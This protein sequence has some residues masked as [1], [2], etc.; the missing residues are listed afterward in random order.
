MRKLLNKKLARLGLFGLL[1]LQPGS[2]LSS[3]ISVLANDQITYTSGEI[4][5]PDIPS[6]AKKIDQIVNGGMHFFIRHWHSHEAVIAEDAPYQGSTDLEKNDNRY[7]VLIDGY[8]YPEDGGYNFYMVHQKDNEKEGIKGGSFEKL[9][10]GNL[11]EHYISSIN[12]KEGVISLLAN[13]GSSDEESEE[14]FKERFA[15]FAVYAG[16]TA[17]Q[18][19]YE[20]GIATITIKYDKDVHLVK[21]HIFYIDETYQVL[22]EYK[23]NMFTNPEID[24]M[25][26]VT[27]NGD[28]QFDG[29]GNPY[30]ALEDMGTTPEGAKISTV[31]SS[32]EGLHTTKTASEYSG[33]TDLEDGRTFNL[34][35]EAWYAEDTYPEVGLILDASGSMSFASDKPEIVKADLDE[36]LLE[37]PEFQ[38]LA[39][40][41]GIMNKMT[42]LGDDSDAFPKIKNLIGYYR[43]T[44]NQ[45][46]G[47]STYSSYR[48]WALNSVF[49]DALKKVN[50][51]SEW[52]EKSW[53]SSLV[54]QVSFENLLYNRS[55]NFQKDENGEPLI[56]AAWG[57]IPIV[58]AEDYGI[59][60]KDVSSRRDVG[61]ALLLNSSFTSP[62]SP[63]GDFSVSFEYSLN[64]SSKADPNTHTG[65]MYI[66]NMGRSSTYED[67][68]YM[69]L[70][71]DS[72]FVSKKGETLVKIKNPSQKPA[73]RTRFSLVFRDRK[74]GFYDLE[75]YQGADCIYRSENGVIS[76]LDNKDIII[77]PS[78]TKNSDGIFVDDIAVYDCALEFYEIAQL[79]V[80]NKYDLASKYNTENDILLTD[81]YAKFDDKMKIELTKMIDPYIFLN[82]QEIS[83]FMN[84][85]YTDNSMLGFSGYK[86][87][88][89]DRHDETLEYVPLAYWDGSIA[90][91]TKKT[92]TKTDLK[93]TVMKDSEENL[94]GEAINIVNNK[95]LDHGWF[96]ITNGGSYDFYMT[97]NTGK[98]LTGIQTNKIATD[99]VDVPNT[100]EK[101]IESSGSSSDSYR[102][103]GWSDQTPV[104]FY[105]DADQN[106][107]CFFSRGSDA[108]T[109]N[110]EKSTYVRSSYVYKLGDK[111]YSKVEALQRALGK[112]TT[113]L[114][115]Q[116]PH[117]KV[118]AVRFS[119]KEANDKTKREKL[120]LLDWTSD[121]LES[122]QLLSLQRG[123]GANKGSASGYDLSDRIGED[124]Q[125]LK[126]Y[127]YGLTGWTSTITGLEAFKENLATQKS[128][129]NKN[130]YIVIFT[131]GKD[132]DLSE[133]MNNGV[134]KSDMKA[135]EMSET[136]KSMGYTIFTV[137]LN[138]GPVEL[139]GQDYALAKD[140]LTLIS[141]KKGSTAEEREKYFFSV[142]AYADK[143]PNQHPVDVLTSIFTDEILTKIVHSLKEYTVSD[144][145]DPRFDLVDRDNT[146]WQLR[147]DGVVIK[148]DLNGK[149]T[150][151]D[152]NQVSDEDDERIIQLSKAS[153]PNAREP[154]L[155]FDSRENVK[156]YY[157]EWR[158]QI[159]PGSAVG[160]T[161]VS[162]WKARVTVRAKDD[163][164]GG[165]DILTNG[166]LS[167]QNYVYKDWETINGLEEMP[168][169]V[170]NNSSGTS[171]SKKTEE[172][173]YPSKGFPRTT[174]N[175]KPWQPEMED[176]YEVIYFGESID[177]NEIYDELSTTISDDSPV[178]TPLYLDYLQRFADSDH[179]S[180]WL[181]QSGYLGILYPDSISEAEL[182]EL[183]AYGILEKLIT[184][185]S[186]QGIELP[187]YYLDDPGQQNQPGI[188]HKNDQIGVLRYSMKKTAG[189]VTSH[190]SKG[191]VAANSVEN[192]KYKLDVRYWPFQ[193]PI[194]DSFIAGTLQDPNK[195][196]S[197][198]E[199][200]GLFL[201][202][203]EFETWFKEHGVIEEADGSLKMKS[204][205]EMDRSLQGNAIIADR[206]YS[207]KSESPVYPRDAVGDKYYEEMDHAYHSTGQVHG[208]LG[209]RFEIPVADLE[210]AFEREIF[211]DQAEFSVNV[212][213]EKNSVELKAY[214]T[215][216]ELEALTNAEQEEDSKDQDPVTALYYTDN[217][218]NKTIKAKLD[219]E[220]PELLYLYTNSEGSNPGGFQQ[221]TYTISVNP[222]SATWLQSFCLH[223]DMQDVFVKGE[224]YQSEY[225]DRVFI[226][227]DSEEDI[228]SVVISELKDTYHPSKEVLTTPNDN[229]YLPALFKEQDANNW[230]ECR[231]DLIANIK[232]FSNFEDENQ[233]SESFV[234]TSV[235]YVLGGETDLSNKANPYGYL[236]K[237]VGMATIPISI[238]PIDPDPEPV[239]PL[240]E[241]GSSQPIWLFGAGTL[242]L[243]FG[244]TVNRESKKKNRVY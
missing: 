74:D 19:K 36:D 202:S 98:R 26:V 240:P 200:S 110:S 79:Y 65:I 41:I 117:S 72:I 177:L 112:F 226:E 93:K 143:D 217:E 29:N 86:Y 175:V 44:K 63:N 128:E 243:T 164:L 219:P 239:A 160:E 214:I 238:I 48:T 179:F 181:K 96:Y 100:G 229:V 196:I 54:K 231:A 34:D 232:P 38:A 172:D 58:F 75:F 46:S 90:E 23:N 220:D 42:P 180:Q 31:Y 198:E 89:F 244:L 152:L 113:D 21:A 212:S 15:G 134:I 192:V 223:E 80:A 27:V 76:G 167:L 241:T 151:L 188:N 114:N 8:I 70:Q 153:T 28:V 210:E 62:L 154:Y 67:Y 82:E 106:L 50:W 208:E 224:N 111:E 191:Q 126:Q 185:Y 77:G 66:G 218:V 203:G 125:R 119:T 121:P 95:N 88:V 237:R 166:N 170:K 204:E 236:N 135:I 233:S 45:D 127:N 11:P 105:I 56:N 71:D 173:S 140:F 187:Y 201:S 183:D 155:M 20:N 60:P 32:A 213:G 116:S 6:D 94:L 136:L 194:D 235:T 207:S 149:E 16:Q 182:A 142:A 83:L 159:I 40:K 47:N 97:F 91:E 147:A 39:Q 157:L 137:M 163:F 211:E 55:F 99:E 9:D 146:I 138:G 1:L 141:G 193:D 115:E 206:A 123:D 3:P 14:R 221:G 199:H 215:K 122:S 61:S 109:V 120:V 87:F 195:E 101:T 22:G 85:A 131:D 13:P 130:K 176:S 64:N 12:T 169:W 10:S 4:L 78:Q 178:Q 227:S 68:I 43:V 118:S 156:A 33:V 234:Q 51:S 230:Q 225:E 84:P 186:E 162:E 209:F 7:F 197:E 158:D 18:T 52:T 92:E 132:S 205:E 102:E 37:L 35:L 107:R 124:G 228:E 81:K 222:E 145:I 103:F 69:Y 59:N 184:L 108:F 190:D 5:D 73:D 144:Y 2:I 168:D 30:T 171:D 165:N 53:Y 174:V 189:K 49:K 129:D 25:D 161:I 57:T 17:A 133:N 148:K 242:L 24:T 104:K 216:E 139:D 150:K